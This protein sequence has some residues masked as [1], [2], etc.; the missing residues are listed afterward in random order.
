MKLPP[1]PGVYPLT[2]GVYTIGLDKIFKPFDSAKDKLEDRPASLLVE[3]QP[4]V[5]VTKSDIILIDP[6]LGRLGTNRK[7]VIFDSLLAKGIN[8]SDVTL[9]L[10]SHLHKDHAGGVVYPSA[11]SQLFVPSF[12]NAA[13]YVSEK[14]YGYAVAQPSSLSYETEKLRAMQQFTKLHLLADEGIINGYIRYK[15]SGGHTP[16]HQTFLIKT[17]EAHYFYGGDVLPQFGQL[18]R[19]FIAKYDFD[20]RASADLRQKFGDKAAALGW[21]CLFFHD[22][23]IPFCKVKLTEGIFTAIL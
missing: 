19:R 3:I 12:P 5:I 21:T 14:E 16:H 23:K 2:E 8:P 13:Y 6:G 4:F 22:L 9:V 15:E 1:P 20:G 18:Q 17:P 10:L 7:P 11:S